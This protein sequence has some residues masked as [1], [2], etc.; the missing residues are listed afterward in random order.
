[1]DKPQPLSRMPKTRRILTV[2]TDHFINNLDVLGINYKLSDEIE[3]RIHRH[4]VVNIRGTEVSYNFDIMISNGGPNEG[5]NFGNVLPSHRY[6]K[7]ARYDKFTQAI[8]LLN[9]LEDYRAIH[10]SATVL[11]AKF[12]P[13]PTWFVGING[14]RSFPNVT[15]KVVI[16]PQDG[17]RGIGQFVVDTLYINLHQFNKSLDKYLEGEH[18]EEAFQKFLDGFKGHVSYYSRDEDK[19]GE[20]LECLKEQGA[21]VQSFIPDVTAEYR[22]ITGAG[23]EPVYFQKRRFRDENSAYPQATG[24]GDIIDVDARCTNPLAK[25]VEANALFQYL[26]RNVIG[27]LNSIDLFITHDGHWG[28]FEFCNQFGVTGI[29]AGIAENIH[30]KFMENVVASFFAGEN[31]LVTLRMGGDEC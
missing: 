4:P 12:L 18:T 20:G 25:D 10:K 15:G 24:G 8:Q 6:V 28:I 3:L 11:Q 9:A 22:V 26:C 17:A 31:P 5:F 19:P 21:I 2:I 30:A 23:G 27:P 14:N 1:M 16:K 29:P 7:L 13:V